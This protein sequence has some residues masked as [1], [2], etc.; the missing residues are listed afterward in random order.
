MGRIERAVS[1]A[2]LRTLARRRLPRS[3]FEFIDGGAGDERT[4]RDNVDDLARLRLMP[5]VGVDVGTRR[6]AVELVGAT[7]ALPLVLAPTGLAGLYW[8]G[9]ET[10]AARAAEQAGIPFCLSTNSVASIEEVAAA[11]PGGDR[12][13]Q[14]YFLKDP[15]LMSGMLRRAKDSGYRVLCMTLDLAVHGRRERDLRNAFTV[16]LRPRLRTVAEVLARPAWLAGFLRTGVRFGNFADVAPSSGFSSIAQ[17]VAKLC[18]ASATWRTIEAVAREWDGPFVI[19]GVLSPQD[20]LRAVELGAEAV[21]V[22]NHG[23]RQLDHVPSAAAAL[24]AVVQAVAGR[25]Q[26][27]LDGGVRR[28]VDLVKARALGADACMIGRPFLWGLAAAGEAG[29]ARTIEVLREELD[30]A[31]ALLGVPS[32]DAVNADCLYREAPAA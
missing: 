23:G 28:G 11:V 13:F 3:I 6:T 12:W 10:A 21:I 14:L 26:V 15:V 24:P 25:A 1:I 22:S 7:A 20:A 32:V 27:I 2:D 17:H 19:K 5:R 31:L 16:P 18:D 4:L 9:G 8:P 30:I 29:V